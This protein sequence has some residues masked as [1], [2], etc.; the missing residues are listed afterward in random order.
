MVKKN[1]KE[2][3]K[4]I[5]RAQKTLNENIYTSH[6]VN[7]KKI[8]VQIPKTEIE[9]NLATVLTLG[10][11]FALSEME[12]KDIEITFKENKNNFEIIIEK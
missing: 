2:K 7:D 4:I 6:I 3:T 12:I 10:T 8:I 5:S 9:D 11:M 1:K